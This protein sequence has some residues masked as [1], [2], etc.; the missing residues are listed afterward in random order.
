MQ[1]LLLIALVEEQCRVT[2]RYYGL[3]FMTY[4]RTAFVE[5][6]DYLSF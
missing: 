4:L 5:K 3:A 6:L 1:S 2:V